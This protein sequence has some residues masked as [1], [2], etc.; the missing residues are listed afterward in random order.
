[1]LQYAF[2]RFALVPPFALDVPHWTYIMPIQ[3]LVREESLHARWCRMTRDE[4]VR[5]HSFGYVY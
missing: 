4:R 3:V 5:R 1:M 2:R